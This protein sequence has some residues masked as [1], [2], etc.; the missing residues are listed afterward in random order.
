MHR[1]ML[2]RHAK[3]VASDPGGDRARPLNERG[4]K[5]APGIGAYMKRER[6]L[7]DLVLCSPARRTRQTFELM[8]AALPAVPPVSF[9]DDLYLASPEAIL[10]LIRAANPQ[11][12]TLLVI[13]HNP[14]MHQAALA[15]AATGRSRHHSLLQSKFPTAAL[16]VLDFEIR[17]WAEIAPGRGILERFVTPR[18]LA[19][20]E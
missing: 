13:G 4:R 7:P 16:A 20:M 14:G 12:Q 9:E 8:A 1:L 19:D 2:L 3:T 15:L 17:D 5:D 11:M 10:A 6:L 18:G